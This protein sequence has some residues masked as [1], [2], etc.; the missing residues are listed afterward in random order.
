MVKT[1]LQISGDGTGGTRNYKALGIGGTVNV[2]YTEEGVAAFWKGIYYAP[3]DENRILT[4]FFN[5]LSRYW[6]CLV[7]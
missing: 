7:A 5:I 6:S 4:L 2:I 3:I 1:R